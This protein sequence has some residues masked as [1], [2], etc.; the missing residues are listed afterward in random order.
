MNLL[1]MESQSVQPNKLGLQEPWQ[2]SP[3]AVSN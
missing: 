1:L 2:L 3:I